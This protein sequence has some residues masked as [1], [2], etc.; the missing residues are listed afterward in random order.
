MSPSSVASAQSNLPPPA[1]A[2]APAAGATSEDA[3]APHATGIVSAAAAPHDLC[4]KTTRAADYSPPA[5]PSAKQEVLRAR[6][7]ARQ[8]QQKHQP[9]QPKLER[10]PSRICTCSRGGKHAAASDGLSET[11]TAN[12]TISETGHGAAVLQ[13]RRYPA[14]SPAA[15]SPAAALCIRGSRQQEPSQASTCRSGC[16]CAVQ[17]PVAA[18]K[19]E[20]PSLSKRS[21]SCSLQSNSGARHSRC[22]C[23]RQPV[24]AGSAPHASMQQ[25]VSKAAMRTYLDANAVWAQTHSL[26]K[27]C[28]APS[29]GGGQFASPLPTG[30]ANPADTP[31]HLIG[32]QRS[33]T[34]SVV[35]QQPTVLALAEAAPPAD[36]PSAPL[37]LDSRARGW[38]RVAS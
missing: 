27:P 25:G 34:N 22:C 32:L 23:C 1:A 19:G 14:A 30:A 6:R 28:L 35:K 7:T 10:S 17:R 4:A 24:P 13:K 38:H 26:D 33:M 20:L 12:P 5:C 31:C 16:N 18:T 2:A 9:F 29:S 21:G 15:A 36:C 8:S 3:A 11:P 37:H